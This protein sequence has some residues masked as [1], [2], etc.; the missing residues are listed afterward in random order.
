MHT[1]SLMAVQLASQR[2]CK[3]FCVLAFCSAFFCCSSCVFVRFLHVLSSIC[4]CS[5]VHCLHARIANDEWQTVHLPTSANDPAFFCRFLLPTWLAEIGYGK[6]HSNQ[7]RSSMIPM[8]SIFT[9]EVFA[10][11]PFVSQNCS[12]F[13]R[14]TVDFHGLIQFSGFSTNTL[15]VS[16]SRAYCPKSLC[17]RAR[18]STIQLTASRHTV[19]AQ[20]FSIRW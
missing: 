7:N 2:T 20:R 6:S 13:G 15:C 17:V 10:T 9:M 5:S 4:R 1:H 14:K 11:E 18:Y 12:L 3:W 8:L 16:N 19:S